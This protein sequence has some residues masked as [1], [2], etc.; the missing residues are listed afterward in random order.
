MNVNKIP[1]VFSVNDHY[2]KYCSVALQSIIQNCSKDN[3]YYIYILY[4]QITENAKEKLSKMS[5]DNIIIEYIDVHDK[6][7]SELLFVDGHVTEETYYRILIPDVLSQWKKVIY[8]D[9][10]I[11]CNVDIELLMEIDIAESLIAGVVT[12]GNENRKEYTLKYLNIPYETYINAGVLVFNNEEINRRF[13]G[14]FKY[15]CYEYLRKKKV[16]KWHD[17]DLLNVVCY[18]SIYYLDSR[19]NTSLLRIITE[20]NRNNIE[21][22]NKDDIARCYILHYASNKPWNSKITTVSTFFWL[23]AYNSPFCSEIISEYGRI[24]DVSANFYSMCNTG[25]VSL[26]QML[27]CL[28]ACLKFR[29]KLVAN[30]LVKAHMKNKI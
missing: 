14:R 25:E 7:D 9:V 15:Y 26:K 8:L 2:V 5:S 21:E 22:I 17:Q 18:P 6:I 30:H 28:S 12:V 11:V 3:F 4:S 23:Y 10:D 19:W 27:K 1:I 20:K 29:L 24:Y 16:L 13:S